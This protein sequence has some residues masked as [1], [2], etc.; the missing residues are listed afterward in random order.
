MLL[1]SDELGQRSAAIGRWLSGEELHRVS[2][3]TAGAAA[4]QWCNRKEEEASVALLM[5]RLGTCI[6]QISPDQGMRQDLR[7]W[8]NGINMETT[9][10]WHARLERGHLTR[11][12][13]SQAARTLAM[14]WYEDNKDAPTPAESCLPPAYNAAGAEKV[15]K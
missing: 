14:H 8:L 3:M 5:T 7:W 12:M 4:L 6:A 15:H 10:V 9:Q 1:F 2:T 13:N 11:C